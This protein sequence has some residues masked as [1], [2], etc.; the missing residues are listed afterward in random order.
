[1]D[2][3]LDEFL[4]NL[5]T[6]SMNLIKAKGFESVNEIKELFF[7]NPKGKVLNSFRNMGVKSYQEIYLKLVAYDNGEIGIIRH[8]QDMLLNNKIDS[9]ISKLNQII[10]F[11]NKKEKEL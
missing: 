10:H 8:T 7:F 4:E 3:E 5:S 2:K 6:R 9:I 11:I 1:M